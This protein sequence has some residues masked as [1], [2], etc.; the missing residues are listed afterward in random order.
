LARAQFKLH[1]ASISRIVKLKS[2]NVKNIDLT[3]LPY[4]PSPSRSQFVEYG[5]LCYLDI[6]PHYSKFILKQLNLYII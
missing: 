4:I 3:L 5:A 6:F 1:F 2:G